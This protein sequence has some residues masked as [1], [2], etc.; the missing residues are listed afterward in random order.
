[1]IQFQFRAKIYVSTFGFDESEICFR[2]LVL[3]END[4]IKVI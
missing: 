4:I 3:P 1:M 2:L